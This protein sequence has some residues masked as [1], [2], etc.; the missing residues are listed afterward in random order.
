[1]LWVSLGTLVLVLGLAFKTRQFVQH[2]N[3]SLAVLH[4][5]DLTVT[6]HDPDR[7]WSCDSR[8]A[9]TTNDLGLCGGCRIRLI[10]Q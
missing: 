2:M 1:M 5:D 4:N 9:E 10:P 6:L 8:P 3:G 7:C